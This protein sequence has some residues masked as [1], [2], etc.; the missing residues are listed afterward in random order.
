MP[1]HKY[2]AG[3]HGPDASHALLEKDGFKW[4]LDEETASQ[5][6]EVQPV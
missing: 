1:L 5:P 3:S 6:R 4:W 2:A